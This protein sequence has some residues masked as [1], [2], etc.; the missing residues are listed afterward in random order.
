MDDNNITI[1]FIITAIIA[2]YNQTRKIK[3]I[4]YKIT[5]DVKKKITLTELTTHLERL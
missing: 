5:T 2:I 4:K 3:K 1:F